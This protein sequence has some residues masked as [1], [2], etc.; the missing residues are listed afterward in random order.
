[1]LSKRD[2]SDVL[3]D[4]F[5]KTEARLE[6]HQYEGCTATVLLVWKDNEENFFAQCANLGDSACVIQYV[7]NIILLFLRFVVAELALTRLVAAFLGVE[8]GRGLDYSD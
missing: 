1:V 5:A 6:E 3:R 8:R 7:K 4:M 2:A